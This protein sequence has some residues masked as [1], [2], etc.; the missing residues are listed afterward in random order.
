LFTA[1]NRFVVHNVEGFRPNVNTKKGRKNGINGPPILGIEQ[2]DDCGFSERGT[3]LRQP[4]ND[5]LFH[6]AASGY[7]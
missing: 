3:V 4:D 5:Q 7:H 6:T 1:L 2:K